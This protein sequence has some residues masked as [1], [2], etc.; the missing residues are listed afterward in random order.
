M[1]QAVQMIE[2]EKKAVLTYRSKYDDFYEEASEFRSKVQERIDTNTN[3]ECDV[4]LQ[5]NL[6]Q[7]AVQGKGKHFLMKLQMNVS[8]MIPKN[9]IDWTSS[10]R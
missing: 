7:K 5:E 8:Q 2:F 6:P 4:S 3:E 9:S 10:C 1:N